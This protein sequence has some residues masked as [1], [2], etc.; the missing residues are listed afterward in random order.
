ML[1]KFRNVKV[2]VWCKALNAAK[3][4]LNIFEKDTAVC[5]CA[6]LCGYSHDNHPFPFYLFVKVLASKC[7]WLAI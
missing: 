4:S 7:C 5:F 6:P 2:T 3:L 1:L